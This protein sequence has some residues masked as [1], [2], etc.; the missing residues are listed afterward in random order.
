MLDYFFFMFCLLSV[1]NL[2]IKGLDK[3]FYDYME[4]QNTN[5]IKGIFVWLIIFCHKSKYGK[6]KNYLH[7]TILN[8]LGQKVVSM[9]LFYSGFGILESLKKKGPNY[10]K[11][12]KFKSIILFFK[13]Q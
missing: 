13:S 11:T 3:F 1:I 2:K 7:Y 5:S 8:Y 4:I 10:T 9:F 12:L 6:K